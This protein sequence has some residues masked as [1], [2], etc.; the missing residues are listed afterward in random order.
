MPTL[1]RTIA[2]AIENITADRNFQQLR[3]YL[4][5]KGGDE[6]GDED[7]TDEGEEGDEQTSKCVI[8]RRESHEA[9]L[10]GHSSFWSS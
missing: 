10:Q 6:V 9:N 1:E 3:E 4:E 2:C 7:N 8:Q 5:S